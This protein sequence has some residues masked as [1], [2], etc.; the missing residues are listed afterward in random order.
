MVSARVCFNGCFNFFNSYL[1][2]LKNEKSII[3]F[4]AWNFFCWHGLRSLHHAHVFHQREDG[5]LYNLLLRWKLHHKLFLRGGHDT[6]A[7][8]LRRTQAQEKADSSGC[9]EGLRLF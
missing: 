6:R 8:D 7:M 5:Y 2:S 9:T 4:L 1:R 3:C